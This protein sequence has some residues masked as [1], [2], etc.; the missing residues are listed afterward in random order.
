MKKIV[1]LLFVCCFFAGP[2]FSQNVEVL[3]FKANLACCHARACNHLENQIK[4]VVEENFDK[5][6]VKFKTIRLIDRHNAELVEKYNARS[7]TVI[8]VNSEDN[9]IDA[10]QM[11]LNFRRTRNSAEFEKDF[12]EAIS[13]L[14]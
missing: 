3:Y 5:N 13:R 14:L 12:V 10:S 1:F 6:Q 4:Q 8:I 9:S 7:Q 2:N 11:V